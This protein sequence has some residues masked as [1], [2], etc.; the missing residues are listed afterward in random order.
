[1]NEVYVMTK[2]FSGSEDLFPNKDFVSLQEII[3]KLQELQQELYEIGLEKKNDE[4]NDW[5]HYG[6]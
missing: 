6:G 4:H 3:V 5:W 1:M 2:D